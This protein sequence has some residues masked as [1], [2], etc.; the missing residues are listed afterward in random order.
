MFVGPGPVNCLTVDR[1]NSTSLKVAWK[2]L[3]PSN[4]NGIISS[5]YIVARF[6]SNESLVKAIQLNVA[7]AVEESTDYSISLVGI[8]ERFYI[9]CSTYHISY[10]YSFFQLLNGT[11]LPIVG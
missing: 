9:R 10:M 3:S 8:G 2:S 4:K 1:K 5:Y 6:T 11:G 7:E